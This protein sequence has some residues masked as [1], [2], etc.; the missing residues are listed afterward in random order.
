LRRSFC[1]IDWFGAV[2]IRWALAILVISFA[3]FLIREFA[4]ARPIVSL[5]ILTDRNFAVGCALIAAFGALLYG[6][7]TLLPLFYQTL[8]NYTAWAAGLAVSPRGIGA[9]AIMPVIGV[10]TG[11]M[12]NR[13]LIAGGFVIFAWSTW[14][15]SG[16][17]LQV[18]QWS[19]LWPIIIS[20]MGTGL[21]FVPLSTSA[22]GTLSNEQMGNATGRYNL[23]RNIGGSIGI[24]LV[25][26]L[27]ARRQQVHR[28]ELARYLSPGPSLQQTVLRI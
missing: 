6:M 8:M 20:G 23:L 13:S 24:S 18:S 9:I 10:L 14:W 2:W 11:K 27:V 22:V 1:R 28:N 4:T 26:T 7:V 19:L 25:E 3:A 15:I 17:T 12:D 5:R 16:L 21:M